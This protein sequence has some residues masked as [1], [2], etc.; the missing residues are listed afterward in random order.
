MNE[1]HDVCRLKGF[2][3][4]RYT[5]RYI[6]HILTDVIKISCSVAYHIK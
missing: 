2:Q 3:Q 5:V 6:R 4:K 1:W